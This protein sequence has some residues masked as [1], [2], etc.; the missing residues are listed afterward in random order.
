MIRLQDIAERAQVS[1]MTVSKSLRDAPDISAATKDRIRRLA[2]EM[3]YVPNSA[4]Q[5]L[6]NRRTQLFGLIIPASTD[7]SFS[8]ISMAIEERAFE[9]GFD[10]ICAHSLNQVAR[11]EHCIR[12]MLAR[13]VDG[14][15]ICPTYRLQSK[16]D[17]FDELW[18][19]QVPTVILGHRAPFCPNFASVETEDILGSYKA[20][21]HLLQLGHRRIAFLAGNPAS[22]ASQ[23]RMEGYRRA[24]RE[25]GLDVDDSLVFQAGSTIEEGEKATA[26]FAQEKTNAT[27][28]QAVNDLVAIGA[29]SF[30]LSQG[31]KIPEDCSVAGF[32]N[33]L[34]SEHF[35]VPLTT[36]RQ[37]KHRLGIAA[38]EVMQ[39]LLQGEMPP[40]RRLI[41]DL[42]IRESTA[43]PRDGR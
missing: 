9:L 10:L 22:P 12:R 4:A 28:V 1:I 26:Q 31:I 20:T 25:S 38:V 11:E 35:R 19:R 27:A 23:E 16:S 21:R 3:G 40:V 5:G 34:V 39:K 8:R 42:V 41:G 29:A 7:P 15:F 36:V 6:R 14:L 33:I 32:G 43:K 30:L 37:P 2:S 24:L 17:V 18:N 13:R